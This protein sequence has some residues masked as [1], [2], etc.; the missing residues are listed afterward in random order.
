MAS[1]LILPVLILLFILVGC[2]SPKPTPSPTP[3]PTPS[4]TPPPSPPKEGAYI[5]PLY[6]ELAPGE[7]VEL[8]LRV[9]LSSGVSGGEARVKFDPSVFEFVSLSLGD[10]FGKEPLVGLKEVD[11]ERGVI[12]CALARVGKTPSGASSGVFMSFKLKVRDNAPAGTYKITIENMGLCDENFEDI[13]FGTQD[14]VIRVVGK[15]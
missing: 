13:K 15:E 6:F 8:S 5:E 10:L 11:E 14:S 7:E 2:V 12:R 1:R 9:K 4:P 3:T